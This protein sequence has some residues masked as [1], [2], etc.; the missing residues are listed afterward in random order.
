M[1]SFVFYALCIIALVIVVMVLK[2]AVS[3]M[4][5]SV[6]TIALIAVLAYIYFMYLR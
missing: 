2:R 4:L 3:C 6:I 5:R 1:N